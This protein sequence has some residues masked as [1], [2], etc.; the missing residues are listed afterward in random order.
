[1][2]G[3]NPIH[4]SIP[5]ASAASSE[6]LNIEFTT[7][8]TPLQKGT[9]TLQVRVTGSD[10][11][12]QSAAQVIVG[13]FMPAMPAMGMAAM[14]TSATLIDKGNGIYQ[15]P[16]NLSS[17]GTWQVSVYV[18]RQGKTIATKQFT[19]SASGGM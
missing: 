15:G 2:A 14:H 1:M 5:A 3:F 11:Q 4:S 16:L 8:P 12:P 9:N 19:M 7:T 17:G 10:G 18:Q 13:F 6:R